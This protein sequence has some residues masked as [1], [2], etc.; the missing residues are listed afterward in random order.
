MSGPAFVGREPERARLE[1]R[2]RAA[3][4]GEGQV[5][6]VAGEPGV[7][8]TRLADEAATRA[9]ALG[10]VVA[11]GRA[12]E[13][14]GSPPYWPFL[15]VFRALGREPPAE[16]SPRLADATVP[17]GGSPQR[18]FR[19]FEAAADALVAEA[20]PGG[21]FVVLDDVQWADSASVRLLVHLSTAMARSRLMVLVTYRDTETAGQ[22]QLRA[23]VAA[24]A[25]ETVVTRMRL[26]GLTEAEV[27]TYLSGV[28]GWEVPVSVASAVCRRTQGNPFFVGELGRLLT[29]SL[30]GQLPDGV[31]D[32][33]RDRLARLSPS[34]RGVVSAGAVLGSEVDPVALAS[35]TGLAFD[36]VLTAL[37]EAA[38]AGIVIGHDGRR[39]AHDL[40]REAARLEL[41]TPERLAL[42][43]RMADYLVGRGDAD[44]RVA[45]VAFHRLESL[46]AGDPAQAVAWAERAAEHARAQYAWE[47]AA[48][49]YRRALD[50]A[51]AHDLAGPARRCGLLLAMADAQVRSFGVADARDT[52]LEAARI[53]R[54]IGDAESIAGAALTMEG[55]SDHLWDAVGRRLC[56]EALGGLPD[57]DS[58]MR[59]RV[60]AL[61]VSMAS[62]EEGDEEPRSAQALAMA[63]RVDDRR[64]IREALRARQMAMSGPDTGRERLA[65][66]DRM[67]ALGA[68]IDDDTV[69][70]GRLWRFDALAQLGDLDGAEAELAPI[71]AV[72]EPLRSPVAS[73]HVVRCRAAIAGA[74]GRFDEAMTF[75]LEAER[76]AHRAGTGGPLLPSQAML[77][78]YRILL[79]E[80]GQFPAEHVAPTANAAASAFIS[81]VHAF[82]L[83]AEGERDRAQRIYRAW[84]PPSAVPPMVRLPALTWMIDFAE[85]FDDRKRA[86]E[87]YQLLLPHAD[88]LVCGGAGIVCIVGTVREALGRAAAM[89]GRLDD[90]VRHLRS[91]VELA[92][93]VGMPPAAASATYHLARV[94][95]R[96]RRSGDR[97]EASAL[98]A[99]T[100][101][102]AH[103]L[104]MRPLV[105]LARELAASL[106][107]NG[108][109]PLTRREG[110]IAV[111][112]S[113]GLT[114]RQIGAAAHISGRTV[115]THVQH[116][117]DKLGFASRAQI[118][119]WVAA[120]RPR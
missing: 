91:G 53:A 29:S 64:A 31:R 55:V 22:E 81:T 108:P 82:W 119:A 35:A 98:A 115:E 79:G 102:M 44:L 105:R 80:P 118:A 32:A 116:I 27:A 37:D 34:C 30:D 18:R 1:E 2:L 59:A 87:C 15:Q 10:V 47:E 117:M 21:L 114:N 88:L 92:E 85:E 42:H 9:R 58:A 56:D 23:A 25:R 75:A 50:A 99:S 76:L 8:K 40:I 14:E 48:A 19:F 89:A 112:V 62:W 61:R 77:V 49:L 7:G 107:E 63:E 104:G 70:W 52:L 43:R 12:T 109:G 33:V 3:L 45:E 41:P 13:D 103:R 110:E 95:A 4:G 36:D 94:L 93:R 67:V 100:A 51:T 66:G 84:P 11:A 86:A 16:M 111:L 97:D 78:L 90:A 69:L 106:A 20:E 113:Q 73:W 65:L 83:L 72:A 46:P 68:G 60:L 54:Q 5:V 120:G 6:L 17:G 96:R 101:A 71:A 39:F 57:G 28:T 26:T 74:R 24:L 38:A